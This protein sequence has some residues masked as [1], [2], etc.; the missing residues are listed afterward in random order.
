MVP[1]KKTLAS[2]TSYGLLSINNMITVRYTQEENFLKEGLL[3]SAKVSHMV[4][5]DRCDALVTR[6]APKNSSIYFK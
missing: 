2:H 6:G 3:Q 5:H 1:Y 4:H